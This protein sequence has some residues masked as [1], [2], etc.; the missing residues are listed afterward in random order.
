MSETII[1]ITGILM[2][3]ILVPTILVLRHIGRKREWEHL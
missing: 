1:P 3:V 2:P